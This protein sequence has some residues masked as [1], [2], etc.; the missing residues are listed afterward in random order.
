MSAEDELFALHGA[1]DAVLDEEAAVI[2][3]L[4]ERERRSAA[5]RIGFDLILRRSYRF[6]R[7]FLIDFG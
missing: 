5:A 2:A 4:D 1:D 6:S 3:A 7:L